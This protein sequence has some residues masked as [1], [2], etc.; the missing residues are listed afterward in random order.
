MKHMFLESQVCVRW[1]F[2]QDNHIMTINVGYVLLEMVADGAYPLHPWLMKPCSGLAN[3]RWRNFRIRLARAHMLWCVLLGAWNLGSTACQH[4]CPSCCHSYQ[5]LLH[6]I[7][8]EVGDIVEVHGMLKIILHPNPSP[9]DASTSKRLRKWAKIVRDALVD[10][11]FN[12][13]FNGS[14]LFWFLYF[15][16]KVSQPVHVTCLMV[17]S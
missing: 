14:M 3:C 10:C 8:E 12:D 6:N 15:K 16:I 9:P 2:V 11:M 1:V 13:C 4:F 7:C 5:R 17:W